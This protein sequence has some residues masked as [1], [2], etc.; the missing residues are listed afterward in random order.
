[1]FT[2]PKS[3]PKIALICE[4]RMIRMKWM[5]WQEKIMLVMRIKNHSTDTLCK[6]VYEE[7]R[8]RSWP[9]LSQEVS[10]ICQEVGLP[11]VNGLNVPKSEVK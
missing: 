1:M 6:Q 3:C 8:E 10:R 2:V 5:I 4:T 9:G 7:G 11:D